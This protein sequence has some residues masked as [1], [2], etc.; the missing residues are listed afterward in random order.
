MR[1][2]RGMIE[3]PLPLAPERSAP[4]PAPH[5]GPLLEQL[6]T[7]WLENAALRAQNAALQERICDLEARRGRSGGTLCRD[8]S[9]GGMVRPASRWHSCCWPACSGRSRS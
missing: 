2:N 9:R 3:M 6:A 1:Y 4:V 8:D 5:H 7:L